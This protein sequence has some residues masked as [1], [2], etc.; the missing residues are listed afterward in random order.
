M[1]CAFS[2][3][4]HSRSLRP[5]FLSRQCSLRRAHIF[6]DLVARRSSPSQHFPRLSVATRL[7]FFYY[8]ICVPLISV[9]VHRGHD[10]NSCDRCH[11]RHC[12]VDDTIDY[13]RIVLDP[14]ARVLRSPTCAPRAS[15]GGH[16]QVV[17]LR[18]CANDRSQR[19]FFAGFLPESTRA[20]L[21]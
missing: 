1:A 14:G 13:H 12:I 18:D 6:F 20:I 10:R 21:A 11:R 9:G 3:R 16:L 8:C 5:L 17:F 15:C 19:P 7:L 4:C 2:R